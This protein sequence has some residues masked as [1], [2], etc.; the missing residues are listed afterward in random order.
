MDTPEEPRAAV[1][2]ARRSHG[3]GTRLLVLGAFFAG[4]SAPEPVTDPCAA[5]V[6]EPLVNAATAETYLG[7]AP[8]QLRAVVAIS[9]GTDP[10]AP[11]CTGAFVTA[12]W[13][14]TAAHCLA[15]PSPRAL[16]GVAAGSAPEV[17][18][19]VDAAVYGTAD[20]ALLRVA[21]RP[22]T[23]TMPLVPLA[24]TD[25]AIAVGDSVELAGYGLTETESTRE[26]RFL[27]EA[28]TSVDAE[29]VVVDGLGASGA[30]E[31]DSG[32]PL[33]VRDARGAVRI[34][35]V[36]TSGSA[37]CLANDRYVR[38]DRMRDW[39][40]AVSGADASTSGGASDE[41]C[42]QIDAVGRCFYGS[43]VFCDSGTLS[44]EAC[45][46]ERAC[47]WDPARS[48]FRCV[49]SAA[50]PCNGV[51]AVGVCRNGAALRCREGLLSRELC[52][53]GQTCRIDGKSGAP[54]CAD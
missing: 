22:E 14:V 31:G 34:G 9:T 54:R 53:C 20:V 42:G 44:A 3:E 40:D 43:A 6:S 29:T 11:L 50:D 10:E 16:I 1:V 13:I 46:G 25:R 35:G 8:E 30:C 38:L 37:S 19:L 45:S 51:D 52:T 36:L 7:L 21:Q 24:S 26:L 41:A 2:V 4:C 23:T 17:V 39:L 32:G 47:G 48:G 15:I 12:D 49:T 5:R 28:V 27:V 18:D 33:L